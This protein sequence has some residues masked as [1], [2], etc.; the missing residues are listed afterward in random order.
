M[1]VACVRSGTKYKTE[2]VYKLKSMVERHLTVPFRFVCLTDRPEELSG[3]ETVT[4]RGLPG[5]WAKLY[6]FNSSWRDSRVL[7]F[8]L[9]TVIC[10]NIDTLSHLYYSFCICRNFTQLAGHKSWPCKYGSC[11]MVIQPDWGEFIWKDFH[12]KVNEYMAKYDAFGDQKL[13][14]D[15]A[16]N[17]IYL[18]DVTP[19]GFFVGYRDFTETKPRGASVLVFA[20]TK[21]PHNTKLNWIK[22]EWV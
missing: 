13:I 14:E 11:C 12:G 15:L 3:I 19:N 5:W 6:L 10:G 4:I 1:I 20:G 8:D 9:D 22:Q 17:A 18:Q 16:P 2:Y 21:K 7:Y